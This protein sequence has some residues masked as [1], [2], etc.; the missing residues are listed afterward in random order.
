MRRY[1]L[2]VFDW[3]GTLLDSAAA[4]VA[5]IQAACRDLGIEP[6]ADRKA[7]EVIGLGLHD[8][9]GTALPYV[10]PADYPH[11]AERYR[12][13]YL[14]QDQDLSLFPGAFS[15]VERLHEAGVL[16]GVATG[17]S[18]RGLDR[19]MATSG[20]ARYFHYT[21][22]ADETHPKPH[23]AMLLEIMEQF[24]VPR[25]KTLMVGDTTHDLLMAR[26]AGVDALAVTF[27]AH[28]RAALLAEQPAAC[29]DTYPDLEAWLISRI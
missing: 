28:P 6:P 16:L 15:L 25:E 13:H 10:A 2:I 8:A 3:D 23:P 18:R 4:I 26:S 17:K 24:A 9:L 21:R 11:V 22:C 14:S 12:Y 29:L 20:L 19:A 27:G 5:S 7:R 1:E